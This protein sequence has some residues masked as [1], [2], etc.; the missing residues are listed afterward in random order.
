V[1]ELTRLSALRSLSISSCPHYA[2]TSTPRQMGWWQLPVRLTALGLTAF[3][4]SDPGTEPWQR[5][6]QR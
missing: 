6:P 3:D 5:D 2:A 1:A 4:L